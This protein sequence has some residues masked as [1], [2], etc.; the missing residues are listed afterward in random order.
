MIISAEELLYDMYG[1][2]Q[3]EFTK[4]Q[5][6]AFGIELSKIHSIASLESARNCI[7]LS[8][9]DEGREIKLPELKRK[10]NKCY[11]LNNIK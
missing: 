3:M 8:I 10:V 7:D 1:T 2:Q 9:R 11:P 5:L 4:N 6:I